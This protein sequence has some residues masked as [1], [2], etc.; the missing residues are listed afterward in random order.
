MFVHRFQSGEDVTKGLPLDWDIVRN[1]SY[2]YSRAARDEFIDVDELAFIL[3]F[4]CRDAKC[5]DFMLDH[6]KDSVIKERGE[7]QLQ[8]SNKLYNMCIESLKDHREFS[9]Y[10]TKMF[11][12][13]TF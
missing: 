5:K 7:S 13:N 10:L 11:S 4:Y 6:A 9:Q 12:Q 8:S 1:P 3:A 2:K